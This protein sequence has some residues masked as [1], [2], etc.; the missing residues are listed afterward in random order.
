MIYSFTSIR[1][2]S[3]RKGGKKVLPFPVL[4]NK[5]A[6]NGTNNAFIK[7]VIIVNL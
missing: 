4:L 5:V 6:Q 1:D 3:D 7:S 2:L